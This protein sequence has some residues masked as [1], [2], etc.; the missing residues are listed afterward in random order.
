[1]STSHIY[2][3]VSVIVI[4]GH[5]FITD[6]S[7][8]QDAIALVTPEAIERF[9]A[10]YGAGFVSGFLSGGYYYGLIEIETDGLEDKR[11]LT[12]RLNV[13]AIASGLVNLERNLTG[14]IAKRKSQIFI[15]RSGGSAS[16]ASLGLEEMIREISSFP[17]NVAQNSS[18]VFAIYRA[19]DEISPFSDLNYS[20]GERQK[21]YLRYVERLESLYFKYRDYHEALTALIIS[22]DDSRNNVFSKAVVSPYTLSTAKDDLADLSKKM[23]AIEALIKNCHED[24]SKKEIPETLYQ[25][26]P[27]LLEVIG[28]V[29]SVNK[30]PEKAEST[31]GSGGSDMTISN[32]QYDVAI[33]G[34]TGV[35]KSSLVNYLYGEAVAVTG[36]GRPVTKRGFERY[37]LKI[38]EL[39]VNLFDS[40]G[41]EVDKMPEWLK[42]LD[43]E[44]LL[45]GTDRPAEEWFHTILY[46]INAAGSRLQDSEIE[47]INRLLQNKYEVVIVLTKADILSEE[48]EAKFVNTIRNYTNDSIP[49]IPVCS[50]VRK[51]RDGQ[52]IHAFGREAIER[53]IY[54]NFWDTIVTRLPQRCRS[55]LESFLGRWEEET[56][57]EIDEQARAGKSVGEIREDIRQTWDD[58]AIE[59]VISEEVIRTMRVYGKISEA[60]ECGLRDLGS[61]MVGLVSSK[62]IRQ[63]AS[64]IYFMSTQLGGAAGWVGS[65]VFGM[66][67]ASL[68]FAPAAVLGA[69]LTYKSLKEMNSVEKLREEVR[70][71]VVTLRQTLDEVESAIG[72]SLVSQRH[73]TVPT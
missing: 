31:H 68:I 9:H 41:L 54:E 3:L 11:E 15:S 73:M 51:R 66:G 24:A 45:R 23:E 40:W 53:Q 63:R 64:D 57:Q 30:N 48:D 14:A 44:L 42:S 20:I 71:G 70:S 8:K 39:G 50:E 65:V 19:Y 67:A 18:R 13:E 37:N 72:K 12:G 32:A 43:E 49:V 35:G 28:P 47:I 4:N 10:I 27:Q 5:E 33:I 59:R 2:L 29:L 22:S 56:L 46:C 38:G 25:I 62:S 17:E 69:Y 6:F 21:K 55:V 36:L 16:S 34:I 1:L 60:V 26:R 52:T 61:P 7:I 58:S